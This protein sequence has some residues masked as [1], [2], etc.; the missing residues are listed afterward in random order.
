[1]RPVSWLTYMDANMMIDTTSMVAMS[2][3]CREVHEEYWSATK[4]YTIH[5]VHANQYLLCKA[6]SRKHYSAT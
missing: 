3:Q 6:C 2:V 5:C 4:Y 1:M